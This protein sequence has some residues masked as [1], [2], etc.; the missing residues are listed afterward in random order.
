MEE[1]G[2]KSPVRSSSTTASKSETEFMAVDQK[3]MFGGSGLDPS[4]RIRY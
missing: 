1:G 4:L 3:T 2:A